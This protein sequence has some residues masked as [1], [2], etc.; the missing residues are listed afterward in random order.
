MS[1]VKVQHEGSEIEVELDGYVA[2]TDVEANYVPKSKVDLIVKDEKAKAKRAALTGAL[3]DPQFKTQ[4]LSA[5]EIDLT[6]GAG[7]EKL[8]DQQLAAAKQD[9]EA[10][11]LKP[12]QDQ[13]A[14]KDGA[15]SKLQNKILQKSILASARA[16]K[17]RDELLET[18]PGGRQPAIVTM[19]ETA[20]GLHDEDGEFYVRK[21]GGDGFEP[22]TSPDR[23]FANIDDYFGTIAKDKQYARFFDRPQ[24]TVGGGNSRSAVSSEPG[25]VASD[26]VSFGN[27]LEGIAK[28]TVVVAGTGA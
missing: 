27:N 19:L 24:Q 23:L 7:G 9:W 22:S 3:N 4:A 28:G 21:T 26:P 12:L 10:R 18:L 1:K 11:A 13:I 5:W 16:N 25:V 6:K 8:S 15:M 14:A 2:Q 17:V 20:F